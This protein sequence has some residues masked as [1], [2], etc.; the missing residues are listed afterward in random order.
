MN[1][2]NDLAPV[3]AGVIVAS[4]VWYMRVRVSLQSRQRVWQLEQAADLLLVHNKLLERFLD[5]PSAPV[6]L[7][8]LVISFSDLMTDRE[9]V[10]EIAEWA[11]KRPFDRPEET[12]ETRSIQDL[13]S[14]MGSDLVEDFGVLIVSAVVGAALRWDESAALIETAFPRLVAAPQ[15]NMAV[16][17][18]ASIFK[19]TLSLTATPMSPVAA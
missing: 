1:I 9:M 6:E 3:F 11:S 13:L 8:R 2:V 7:K 16:V 12:E 15:R 10:R 4:A 18:A 19:A 14:R 17:A 5:A